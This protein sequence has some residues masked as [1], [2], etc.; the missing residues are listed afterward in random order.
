M[1]TSVTIVDKAN[2]ITLY[3]QKITNAL[4]V[5]NDC[6]RNVAKWTNN[7]IEQFGDVSSFFTGFLFNLLGKSIQ[8]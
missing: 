2:A 6:F 7:K 3:I 4:W 1:N 5:C 8:L